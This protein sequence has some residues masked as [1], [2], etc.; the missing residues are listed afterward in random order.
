M[1]TSNVILRYN[2][3]DPLNGAFTYLQ[4]KFNKENV[5]ENIVKINA[6]STEQNLYNPV[7]RRDFING[8]YWRSKDEN[9]SWYEVDFLQNKFY[10]KSYVIRNYYLDYFEKWE[11]L[12][13]NDGKQFDLVDDV[14]DFQKTAKALHNLFFKCKYPK[15]RRVFRIVANGKRFSGDYKFVIHRL[16][17]YGMF[18]PNQFTHGKYNEL[19]NKSWLSLSF[20]ITLSCQ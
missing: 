15:I 5:H 3:N 2:S 17:F 7:I 18:V 14:K 11:V 20:L 16:E 13:S 4:K 12:G 10:L 1:I 8:T 19:S 9:C 6:S